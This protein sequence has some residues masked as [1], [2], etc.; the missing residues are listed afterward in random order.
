MQHFPQDVFH[1]NDDVVLKAFNALDR[2]KS[3]GYDN[4]PASFV[5]TAADKLSLTTM[6]IV[7]QIIRDA[8]FPQ[9]VELS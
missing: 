4:I 3:K 5:K 1:F 2:T 8:K 6:N 7:N 9:D